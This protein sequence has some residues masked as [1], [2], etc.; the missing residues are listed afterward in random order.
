MFYKQ[1]QLHMY[2]M[3]T[4]PIAEEHHPIITIGVGAMEVIQQQLI[5]IIHI[6][7]Q[8]HIVFVQR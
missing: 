7:Q 8:A 2:R 6:T 1:I 3:L 5:Q 4:Q